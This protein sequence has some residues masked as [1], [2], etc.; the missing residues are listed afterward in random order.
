M[1]A[2]MLT[3]AIGLT[4]C[5][6]PADAY[7]AYCEPDFATYAKHVVHLT[8]EKGAVHASATAV[9]L[10]PNALITL[11]T[12]FRAVF[13]EHDLLPVVIRVA[14]HPYE[15]S[16]SLYEKQQRD[17]LALRAVGRRLSVVPNA[18]SDESMMAIGLD[19]SFLDAKPVSLH[20]ERPLKFGDPI[21]SVLYAEDG[22]S[23]YWP[24]LRYGSGHVFLPNGETYRED[25]SLD[26]R[27]LWGEMVT[28]PD[29]KRRDVAGRG[30]AGAPVF[31]C[32]GALMG[33]VSKGLTQE[34]GIG[35]LPTAWGVP[36]ITG[37][38]LSLMSSVL[39][40]RLK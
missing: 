26:P 12:P 1:K 20:Q 35:I 10:S 40:E 31:S 11:D 7:D 33:M 3:A 5:A 39:L 14:S 6:T 24:Q 4:M 27:L 15:Q 17:H 30:S 36:N 29:L 8:V 13:D 25:G 18:A 32:S 38:R 21:F 23:G 19:R 28:A 34:S 9:W 22:T 37:I 16:V 2:I